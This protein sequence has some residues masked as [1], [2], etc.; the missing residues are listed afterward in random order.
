MRA[1]WRLHFLGCELLLGFAATMGF[2]IWICWGNG[3]RPMDDLLLGQRAAVYGTIASLDGALLGFI[4]A[5]A[6]IVLSFAPSDRFETLR[7]SPHY[8]TLWRTFTSTIRFLGAA[9]LFAVGALVGDRDI[10]PNRILMILCL[11]SSFIAALRLTR[12][13]WILERAINVVTTAP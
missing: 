8:Q 3:L 11:G 2:A 10:H 13:A 7:N 9:T 4:I 6:T 5:T 12:S 1:F